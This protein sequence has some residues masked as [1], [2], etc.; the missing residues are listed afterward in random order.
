MCQG[1]G[2][3]PW[4]GGA[5]EGPC[6]AGATTSPG[7]SVSTH[8]T[9]QALTRGSGW[10]G[11]CSSHGRQFGNKDG[12]SPT[13]IFTYLYTYLDAYSRVGIG[14]PPAAAQTLVMSG[15]TPVTAAS[16]GVPL[17]ATGLGGWEG[18]Q[19]YMVFLEYFLTL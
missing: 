15:D 12:D 13:G 7:S 4:K 18:C 6:F 16:L 3:G 1:S 9:S 19:H 2:C 11:S 14:V 5:A 17:F 10:A 8:S